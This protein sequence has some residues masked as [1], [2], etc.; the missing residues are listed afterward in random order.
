MGGGNA[1]AR[2]G[3]L[4]QGHHSPDTPQRDEPYQLTTTCHLH[5]TISSFCF[6]FV[7]CHMSGT[8]HNVK[9]DGGTVLKEITAWGMI[10]K[11]TISRYD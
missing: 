8:W 2:A 7:Q 9:Q 10:S 11:S 3:W 6:F 1:S 5:V 4:A